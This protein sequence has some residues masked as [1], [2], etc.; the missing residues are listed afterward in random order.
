VPRISNLNPLSNIPRPIGGTD[1]AIPFRA[2]GQIGLAY[3]DTFGKKDGQLLPQIGGD[4][5]R[6]PVIVWTDPL[7]DSSQAIKVTSAVKGG[8]QLWDYPHNNGT[9]STV[10]PTDVIEIDGKLY[11]WVMVTAGLGNEKWCELAVSTDRGATWT[12]K[13]PWSVTAYGGKRVMITFD[14]KPG[15]DW[16]DIFSTGGLARDKGM[17]RWRCH[18]DRLE[19]QSAWSGW[20]WNGKDWGWDREPSE[21][22]PGWKFGEICFRWIEGNAVLSGFDAGDYSAF[23]KVGANTDA[24]WVEAKTYRPV[25][26]MPRGV[27][28]V[29]QL[30]GCYVHPDSR[31]DVANGVT[32][33]VS[34]WN[35]ATGNPY[36][37]MQY[38]IPEAIASVGPKTEQPKDDDMTPQEVLELVAKELAVSGSIPIVIKGK[39]VSLREGIAEVVRQEKAEYTLANRPG[40]PMAADDQ[41]GHTMSAR[42]EGLITQAIVKELAV[43]SGIDVAAIVA[44]VKKGL[45]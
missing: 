39:N 35:T 2:F 9:F 15:S 14:R 3:G 11:A 32:M 38:V 5:W 13:G 31:L 24:N 12:N 40:A 30:Y 8:A 44:D 25:T 10:L 7:P 4:D 29:S 1:L 16:V 17:L 18:K 6:S 37:A 26:G 41:Y 23:V 20:G 22:L 19:D 28:T 43:K 21:I 34:T 36:R 27:D 42:A 45:K 33:I